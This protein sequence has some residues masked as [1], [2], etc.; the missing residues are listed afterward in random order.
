MPPFHAIA[1]AG[2]TLAAALALPPAPRAEAAIID[3]ESPTIAG[4]AADIAGD[5]FAGQGVVFRTVRLSG[6][7]AIGDRV[8]QAPIDGGNRIYSAA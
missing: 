5:V 4:A 3:F 6:T 8:Q 7:V 2:L 1:I